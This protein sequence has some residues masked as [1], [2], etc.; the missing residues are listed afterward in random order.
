MRYNSVTE[1]QKNK[2]AELWLEFEPGL[3][4]YCKAK[5]R[6]CEPEI[7]E[8]LA[9][10]KLAL[11]IQIDKRDFPKETKAWLYKTLKNIINQKFRQKYKR[12]ENIIDIDTTLIELPC[13]EDFVK[14]IE[15]NERLEAI[16][17]I[18]PTLK[19]DEQKIMHNT[20]FSAHKIKMKEIA[21]ELGISEAAA[22]QKR[23]RLCR[24][25]EKKLNKF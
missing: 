1:E 13:Q 10:L 18:I 25:I 16:K 2:C 22:K 8:A 11:C 20:Y 4:K 12:E 15:S 5:L 24:N 9:D 21:E 6:G 19:A 7:E 23:Y 3:Q 14:T 17:E